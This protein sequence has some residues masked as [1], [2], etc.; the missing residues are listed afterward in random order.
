MISLTNKNVKEDTN[1]T[2]SMHSNRQNQG[3]KTS[4]KAE[5]YQQFIEIDEE[6]LD[7]PI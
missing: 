4:L 1:E 7:D 3:T 5:D 2:K 6:K